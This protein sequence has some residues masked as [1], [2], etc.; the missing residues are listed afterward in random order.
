M[1]ISTFFI[2]LTAACAVGV[3]AYLVGHA[4]S[5]PVKQLDTV[6]EPAQAASVTAQAN[7]TAAISAASSYHLDHGTYAG[8]TTRDLRSY[9]KDLGSGV[10]VKHVTANGY[11]VES[12]YRRATVSITGPDGTFVSSGC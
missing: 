4:A 1:R 5:Q 6:S 8:M 12:T 10:S 2:T 9:D 3:G 7:L 11:C